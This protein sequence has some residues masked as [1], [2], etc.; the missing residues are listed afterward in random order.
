MSFDQTFVR[1]FKSVSDDH[2]RKVAMCESDLAAFNAAKKNH[3]TPDVNARGEPQWNG[4]N[5]QK[6]LKE[7]VAEGVTTDQKPELLWKQNT[8]FQVYSKK[9]FQD[10]ICQ[11]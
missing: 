4:S 6:H 10:H 11:E 8:E 1:R 5:A 2:K 9:T 7:L 3:P